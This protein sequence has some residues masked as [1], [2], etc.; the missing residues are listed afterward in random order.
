[1]SAWLEQRDCVEHGG[2]GASMVGY[3]LLNFEE[4]AKTYQKGHPHVAVADPPRKPHLIMDATLTW[5]T[6]CDAS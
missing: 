6:H 5:G 3:I 2:S 4:R 1:M